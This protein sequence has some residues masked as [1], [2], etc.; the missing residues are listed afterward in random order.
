MAVS[1]TVLLGLQK[2][3]EEGISDKRQV[4]ACHHPEWGA[5]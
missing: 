1:Q 2:K 4:H 3:V 5:E